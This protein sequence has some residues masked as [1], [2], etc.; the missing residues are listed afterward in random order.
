MSAAWVR[1]SE[2]ISWRTL[3]PVGACGLTLAYATG[4]LQGCTGAASPLDAAGR[5]RLER[6][7]SWRS[8][9]TDA[10]SPTDGGGAENHQPVTAGEYIRLALTR[11]PSIQAAEARVRRLAQ[12]S[13]RARSLDD[14]M[15]MVSPIGEMAQTASGEVTVMT[16]LSQRL[17]LP[18]KL[19]ARARIAELET[20]QAEAELEQVRLQVVGDVR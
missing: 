14:P 12:R 10:A 7:E 8:G 17:P 20:A 11:N 6:A 19:E 9:A 16:T 3:I 4:L 1:W 15:L 18:G 2:S 5:A 13:A